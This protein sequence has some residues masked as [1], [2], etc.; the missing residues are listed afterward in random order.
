MTPDEKRAVAAMM[1]R[2]VIFIAER[3]SMVTVLMDSVRDGRIP[4]QWEKELER[5]RA[6]SEY[7][8]ILEQYA[9][10]IRKLKED[11]DL[12]VLLPLLQKLAEGQLPN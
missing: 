4:E 9:P 2:L 6:T 3:R 7:H 12:E 8:A 11:A 10:T 5:L 1:Q